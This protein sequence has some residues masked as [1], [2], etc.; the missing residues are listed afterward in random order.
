MANRVYSRTKTGSWPAI[1]HRWLKA[2]SPLA[3]G[4]LRCFHELMFMVNE[5]DNYNYNKDCSRP[6]VWGQYL[7]CKGLQWNVFQ[8]VFS[9]HR[10]VVN[11]YWRFPLSMQ[12]K[13][14]FLLCKRRKLRVI[15]QIY[16]VRGPSKLCVFQHLC[17]QR[18]NQNSPGHCVA[19][20]FG[21]IIKNLNVT[22]NYPWNHN[23]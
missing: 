5:D 15:R 11:L 10:T 20:V 21:N 19:L 9:G 1:T 12:Y 22:S 4:N 16:F 17:C 7:H 3:N 14:H 8:F 13:I 23:M 6:F 2:V 18:T